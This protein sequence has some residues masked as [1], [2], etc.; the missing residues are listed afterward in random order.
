MVVKSEERCLFLSRKRKR[1]HLTTFTSALDRMH[2]VEVQLACLHEARYHHLRS[3]IC[4][5]ENF[6]HA[7]PTV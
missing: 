7:S 5:P 3:E 1:E 4:D 6:L 2:Y